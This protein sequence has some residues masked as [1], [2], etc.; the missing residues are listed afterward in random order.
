MQPL[1]PSIFSP[2]NNRPHLS[3][4]WNH[5]LRMDQVMLNTAPSHHSTIS[6]PPNA[7]PVTSSA[8]FSQNLVY[9]IFS[10]YNRL[11]RPF[12][13]ELLFYHFYDRVKCHACAQ[14][15]PTR[16]NQTFFYVWHQSTILYAKKSGFD[17]F[18]PISE[19]ESSQSGVKSN[20]TGLNL[21]EKRLK[22]WLSRLLFFLGP[23]LAEPIKLDINPELKNM[24]NS[25]NSTP[26]YQPATKP[27][28]APVKTFEP[29]KERA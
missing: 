3:K 6:A 2:L 17:Y 22:L 18:W 24:I 20:K 16:Q 21:N 8:P 14:T 15:R 1:N 11:S 23:N 4:Q 10:R 27:V 29:S 12:C 26:V 28:S 7:I 13:F 9:A 5:R 25:D 19:R